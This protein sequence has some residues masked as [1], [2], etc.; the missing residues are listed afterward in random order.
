MLIHGM[1]SLG[2]SSLAARIANRM[3]RHDT[4]VLYERYHA[5]AVFEALL[6]ALPPRLKPEVEGAWREAIARDERALQGALQELL[7]GPFRCEDAQTRSRP[8]LLIVD[9]LEQIL[10]QPRPGQAATPVKADYSR[11]LAA[12]IGAFRDAEASNSRLLLTSRYTFAL[13]DGGDDLARCLVDVPLPPMDEVQRDKQMRA[14]AVL[15]AKAIAETDGE[16]ALQRRIKAAAGGNPGLQEALTR[17]LLAGEVDAA[18]QAVQAVEGYLEPARCRARR[19]P[20]G[21]VLP[22]GLAASLP[23]DADAER[24]AA[25]ARRHIVRGAGAASGA[26]GDRRRRWRGEAGAGARPATGARPGRSVR[27]RR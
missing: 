14:A 11:V 26:A 6:R 23:R 22:A 20:R 5:L 8:I 16:A 13:T 9:D 3:P 1:G 25:A 17:P 21:G 18:E 27:T 4:V 2:K 24:S 12:I 7:E 15:A 10:E 19:A